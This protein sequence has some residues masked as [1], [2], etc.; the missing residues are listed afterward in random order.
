MNQIF[1][2][3]TLGIMAGLSLVAVLSAALPQRAAAAGETYKWIDFNT[4][5]VSGGDLKGTTQFKM[6]QGSANPQRFIA[7]NFPDHEA[8][9]E[10]ELRIEVV[11]NST[12]K[13]SAPLPAM[14]TGPVA[15]PAGAVF[16]SDMKEECTLG[17]FNCKFVPR[18]P[19]VSASY[20]G[21]TVTAQGTRPGDD[22]QSEDDIDKG[23]GVTIN[24]PNPASSSP[25]TITIQ[26]KDPGGTKVFATATPGQEAALGSDDPNNQNYLE[27]DFRPVHYFNNFLLDPGKYI[28]CANIVI[29]DCRAFEKKKF[30]PLFLEYGETSNERS[31]IAKIK[32]KYA[33]GPQD[34]TVGPLEVTLRKADGSI[35]AVQTNT[36]KHEMSSDEEQANGL[37][38]VNYEFGLEGVFKDME[39]GTYQ[40]CIVGEPE[41]KDVTK[42][43]GENAIVEFTI[44]WNVFSEDNAED[45]DCREKYEVMG[46]KAITFL[47]CSIIDTGTYAVGQLDSAI[48]GLL[49]IDV[50][51]IFDD[52]DQGNA[53]HKA[54]NSFRFF[55]LGLLV[56]AALIMVIS[57]AANLEIVSA[58][59]IRKMLPRLLFA[60]VFI[61]LSW[62][63]MEF[64]AGL[65]N[66]AGNG[67]RTLIYAPFREM[68]NAGGN[69]AG[70]S[71]FVL[72][73]ITTG[74]ALAFGFI[75]LLSFVVTGVLASLVAVGVLV[76][77]KILIIL[78]VMMAPF[79]IAAYILPNTNKLWDFWRSTFIAVLV[80]FPII[81]AFIAIGRVFAVVAFNAPGSPTVNQLIAIVAYF[82]PYFLIT[83]AFKMAGG[84][85]ATVAGA[86][87]DRSKGMFDR[88]SNFRSNRASENMSKMAAGRRFQNS[89]PVAR[90]FN[91]TTSGATTFAKSRSKLGFLT[92]GAVRQAAFEQQRSLNAMKYGETDQAKTAEENDLILQAQTYTNERSA[93]EGL[94][95]DF[96]MVRQAQGGGGNYNRTASGRIVRVANGT[97]QLEEN[98]ELIETAIAGARANGGFGRDQ[99]VHAARRLFA[100]GTGYENVL[101]V[102]QTVRRVAGDN[103]DMAAALLGYGNGETGKVNRLDLKQGYNE[104]MRLYDTMVQDGDITDDRLDQAM[105]E[106][107]RGNDAVS[108]ARGRPVVMEN[109]MPAISRALFNAQAQAR[110]APQ[111]NPD[112]TI[113]VNAQGR[114]TQQQA[115]FEV[116]QMNGIIEQ[117]QTQASRYAAP[118]AVQQI[119]ELTSQPTQAARDAAAQR[120]PM[121]NPQLDAQGNPVR[122]ANG[123]VVRVRNNRR[124][125]NLA[126]GYGQQAPRYGRRSDPDR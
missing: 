95:A 90:A 77:R 32:V 62:D 102:H 94:A 7:I 66:D 120:I 88:L 124:D 19:G 89:N 3:I 78:L 126:A 82:L 17:I 26:I 23:V 12:L 22:N 57:Q 16:C 24:A 101:Q 9:C 60:S 112:G 115:Q 28:V 20:N 92:N 27:P 118:S 29:P 65:S 100:T 43:A 96:G 105:L 91:A 13:L 125:P 55:A 69:I 30:E 79:A 121:T 110:Q 54:W 31:V 103:R 116:G 25:A 75:G 59:T 14:P 1:K 64:L 41:C 73:L 87:N 67:I 63:V 109:V 11:N 36:Q 6:V 56:V 76:F 52:N 111:T 123:N 53:Y 84:V 99:Q 117:Y 74:A 72:T 80:V 104:H 86:V 48:A 44:D 38:T 42:Q 50:K 97:G 21:Q 81:M 5:E 34:M 2:K 33:G 119:D 61:A 107:I 114:N 39:P 46:T 71:I 40:V 83:F 4:L 18:F 70:G 68:A 113:M 15:R 45:K 8:G 35:I 58:Y 85:L 98:T 122:D 93:R 10:I 106:A 37:I 108:M 51:D 49:T 47:V